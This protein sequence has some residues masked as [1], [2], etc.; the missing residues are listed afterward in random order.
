[1]GD[2]TNVAI[3]GAGIAG[4]YL[5]R[6]LERGGILGSH[7]HML[8]DF[9]NRFIVSMNLTVPIL[10]LSPSFQSFFGFNYVFPGSDLILLALATAV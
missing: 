4:G 7:R 8:E 1:L 3:V 6:L 5:G 10:V 2:A 9:K